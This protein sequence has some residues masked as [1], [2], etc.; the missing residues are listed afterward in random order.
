MGHSLAALFAAAGSWV[1][2]WEINDG[3]RDTA[4]ERMRTTLRQMQADEACLARVSLVKEMAGI[5]AG[6]EYVTE[7]VAE[8]LRLKCK[9]FA[10]AE[11]R[12]PQAVLASNTS[13]IRISEIAAALQSPGRMLGTHWW[14][15]PSLMP[16]VEVVPGAKS[17]P[18]VAAWTV[19]LL[20]A[21]G[22]VPV[23]L[24]K[25]TPGFIGNRL[26]HALWREA[27]ALVAEGIADAETV[28]L[29][30]RNTLGLKLAAMGPL[31]N[32]DY[33]G[34]DLTRAIHDYV[35]PALSKAPTTLPSVVQAI[36]DG[37]LGAKTG[38]GLMAWPTGRRERLAERLAACLQR[39]LAAE[40]SRLDSH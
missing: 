40:N 24:Q 22:K 34:L 31:E 35:F 30:A 36:A 12:F 15:P 3:L 18:A 39:N 28:D 14:N 25:D 23:L 17:D 5:P 26:Q 29:V 16:I 11:K 33:I 37:N 8:D 13:V 20:S 27:F 4:I 10:E 19:R 7:A 38:Q 21:L 6:T 2:L 9:L 1:Y 32:A